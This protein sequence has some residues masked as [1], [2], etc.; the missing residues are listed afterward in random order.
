MIKKKSPHF[1]QSH[2]QLKSQSQHRLTV[3]AAM[4][5]GML[6]QAAVGVQGGPEDEDARVEAVG[7]AR[8]G[9]R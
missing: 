6:Q 4:T 8:V 9:G 3:K 5:L 1:T 7:P 2:T